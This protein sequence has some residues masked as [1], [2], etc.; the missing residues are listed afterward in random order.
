MREALREADI[1][2]L[3]SEVEAMPCSTSHDP[4]KVR[5]LRGSCAPLLSLL[6][7]QY[8]FMCSPGGGHMGCTRWQEEL[9]ERYRGQML[10]LQ[11][12]V[13]WLELEVRETRASVWPPSLV[14]WRRRLVALTTG[15]PLGSLQTATRGENERRLGREIQRLRADCNA[16]WRGSVFAASAG[17]TTYGEHRPFVDPRHKRFK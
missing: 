9:L 7:G 1:Q 8:K 2:P 12:Q 11:R 3:L 14:S 5:P 13:K 17:P 16:A 4:E 10:L 6:F 15:H